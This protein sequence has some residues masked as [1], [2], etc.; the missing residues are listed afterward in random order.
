MPA[1]CAKL[2]GLAAKE[3]DAVTKLPLRSLL[4]AKCPADPAGDGAMGGDTS[5]AR[6]WLALVDD[7]S[8]TRVVNPSPALATLLQ[9][10]GVPPHA[11]AD[12]VLQAVAD[13]KARAAPVAALW[14]GVVELTTR[15]RAQASTSRDEQAAADAYVVACCRKSAWRCATDSIPACELQVCAGGS[16]SRA[17][18]RKRGWTK[19]RGCHQR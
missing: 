9:A 7:L 13:A 8:V 15:C 10:L 2:T 18:L 6:P 12:R 19:Q 16:S 17:R 3:V 11:P 4:R 1:T 14:V 5:G